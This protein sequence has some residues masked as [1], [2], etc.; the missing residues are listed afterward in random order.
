[1]Y[2]SIRIYTS[3]L[4]LVH[5]SDLSGWR[6]VFVYFGVDVSVYRGECTVVRSAVEGVLGQFRR[7]NSKKVQRGVGGS[8]AS[9]LA[10]GEGPARPAFRRF[11]LV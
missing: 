4:L 3:R 1:M 11:F 7:T 8:A 5:A 6:F 2:R 9:G 10:G